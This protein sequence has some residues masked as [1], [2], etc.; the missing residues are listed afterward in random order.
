MGGV[1]NL[2]IYYPGAKDPSKLFTCGD[3]LVSRKPASSFNAV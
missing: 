2:S 1:P 3:G